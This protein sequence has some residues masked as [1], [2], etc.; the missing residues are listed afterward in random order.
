MISAPDAEYVQDCS[1]G[2]E[3]AVQRNK[4][5]FCD[6]VRENHSPA[7]AARNLPNDWAYE[8]LRKV[9]DKIYLYSIRLSQG[10]R[11]YFTIDEDKQEMTILRCGDHGL[12]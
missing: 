3:T 8:R 9:K 5:T 4:D 2:A 12:S 1:E 6:Y 7:E 10:A 11:L